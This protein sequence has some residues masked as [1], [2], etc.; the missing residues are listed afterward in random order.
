[1]NQKEKKIHRGSSSQQP[2]QNQVH[3]NESSRYEDDK[4][5]HIVD[6]IATEL[7]HRC[8]EDDARNTQRVVK[9][10]NKCLKVAALALY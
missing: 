2:T 8:H 1:M 4:D 10:T 5:R 9:T 3:A 7:T 6:C